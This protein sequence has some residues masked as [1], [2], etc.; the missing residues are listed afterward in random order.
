MVSSS[1]CRRMLARLVTT[2]VGATL[3]GCVLAGAAVSGCAVQEGDLA[4]W[5]S[6]LGG[7]RRLSAVV[8]FDK[9]PLD[10]RVKAAMSLVQMKPRKGKHVGIDRLV[11][12]TLV[13]DPEFLKEE[14]PCMKQELNPERRADIIA[15]MVPLLIAELGKEPPKPTQGGQPA[16]DPSFKFKDAAYLMLTYEGTQVIADQKLR[17]QLEEALTAWAMAD[18]ERRLND[19]TQAFGMEQ[20]LRHIGPASVRQLPEKMERNSRELAQMADLIAKIGSTETKEA[21]SA[22]L[23]KIA[24][25]VAS[26]DWKTENAAKLKEANRKAGYDLPEKVFNEQLVNYQTE[27][28]TRVFG[29]M[30]KIGGQ[31]VVEYALKLGADNT[32]PKG[33]DEEGFVKRRAL[34]LASISGHVD[35][36]NKKHVDSLFAIASDPKVPGEV[37]DQAFARIRELPREAVIGDLY[38]FFDDPNWQRR[39]LAGVT[40]LKISD[41]KHIG[42]FLTKLKEKPAKNFNPNEAITYGAYL[43]DLKE[44]DPLKALQPHM[45]SGDAKVRITA[46]SYW[47]AVG[48]K[49]QLGQI[50]AFEGDKQKA[51]RC[52]E[53]EDEAFECLWDCVVGKETKK[54]TTVGEYVTFCMK[55]AME[56]RE[57]KKDDGS[58]KEAPKNDK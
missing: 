10:I 24:E 18:F 17:S 28:L 5:E 57:P 20:L 56:A 41:A 22:Q 19:S 39:R 3:A 58:K 33:L 44:G 50:K 37:V 12:G 40:I 47:R 49:S 48:D 1:R 38:K 34:A 14:E 7:P 31:A 16:P 54:V 27:S 30:K 46:L 45:S 8:L 13:C 2:A 11:K 21:A 42:E 23:V 25:F 36:K 6:T 35:R 9:Y 29:S 51:P 32:V 4:R 52:E 26:E 55:P 43:A 53:K 15:E